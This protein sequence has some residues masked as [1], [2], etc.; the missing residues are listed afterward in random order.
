MKKQTVQNPESEAEPSQSKRMTKKDQIISLYTSGIDNLEDIA[1]MTSTRPGYAA[2]VLQSAGLIA[3]YFDL[4][5]T[6]AHPMNTYSRFFANKLGFK[7][8]AAARQSVELINR[9]YK[10]FEMARDRAGQHHALLMALTMYD[11]AR[12][13]GKQLEAD[14]FRQ[15]LVEQ[16]SQPAPEAIPATEFSD[17]L[18][19]NED[20]LSNFTQN[21]PESYGNTETGQQLHH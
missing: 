2:S 6:T 16:L 13:T 18:D 8:E 1:L 7:D 15:W 4:Y 20:E 12:W 17:E 14:L 10:Q 19:Q 9:L 5:T 21:N 3:G 11:R